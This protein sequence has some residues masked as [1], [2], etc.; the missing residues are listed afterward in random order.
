MM[1]ALQND[2]LDAI[3]SFFKTARAYP[4]CI[5]KE[6]YDKTSDNDLLRRLLVD[7]FIRGRLSKERWFRTSD[8][9]C[10]SKEFLFDILLAQNDLLKAELKLP[11]TNIADY[12]VR[13]NP[14]E[15]KD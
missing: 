9:N 3:W 6:V 7:L 14:E 4:S 1:P 15:Q 8:K 12:Y 2:A 5:V 10:Y 13:I 11:R